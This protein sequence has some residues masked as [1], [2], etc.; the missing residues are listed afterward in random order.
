MFIK[1]YDKTAIVY[2]ER[3]I[4]YTN[5]IDMI[6][7]YTTLY[8]ATKRDRIAIF[9]ENCPEWA[10]AFF[11]SWAKGGTNV[12]IDM[13]STKEEVA[14]ILTDCTPSVIF[15]SDKTSAVMDEA[16]N[17]SGCSAAIINLDKTANPSLPSQLEDYTFADSDIPLILYT[18]GTTGTSKGVMLSWLNLRSNIYWNNSNKRINISDRMLAVLPAHHSWPL[19]ATILCPFDCGAT[20]VYLKTLNAEELVRTMKEQK[21]TMLTAVPR[22]FEMLHKGIMAKIKA[23]AAARILFRL[24]RALDIMPL[25]RTVFAKVHREFGG[26]IKVWIAGGAKLDNEIIK[27]YRALGILMLEGYGLTETSPM[28]T[29]HPF[30]NQR[31]G[32]VGRVFDETEIRFGEDDEIMLKGP[33][34]MTGY[35]NK[36]EAT[37]EVLVDG[38]LHTGDLG[39]IDNDRFLYITGRKKDIIVLPNGKNI[40]PDLIEEDILRN[41]PLI[42]ECAITEK[43]GQLFAIIKTDPEKI[44]EQRITNL[45]ETIKWGVI[46]L[47]NQNAKSY[48]RIHDF[49]ITVDDL[50]RTRMGKLRRYMLASFLTE[51]R[52]EKKA[53][54]IPTFEE[55]EDIAKQIAYLVDRDVHPDEHFEID[56]GMDSLSLVELQVFAEKTYGVTLEHGWTSHYPTVKTFAEHIRDTKTK[57][58]LQSFDWGKILSEESLHAPKPRDWVLRVMLRL[59]KL[60]FGRRVRVSAQGSENIPDGRC[61]IAPNHQSFI[62]SFVLMY[63]LPRRVRSTIFF[64]A[65]EKNFRSI[66]ARFFAKRSNTIIMDI[67]R[68]L[69]TSIRKIAAVLKAGYRV[70]IFPEGARSRSGKT[71]LFKKTFAIIASELGIPVVPVAIKGAYEALPINA[72]LPIKSIVSVTFCPPVLPSGKDALA[73]LEETRESILQN[74]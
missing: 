67:N 33:H 34:I 70:V 24:T 43:E 55:Y 65:K 32:S 53:V 40:R 38:W 26:C 41:Y 27:D 8:S 36:P 48:N 42:K 35:W 6:H 23:N 19:M 73:V 63:R 2:G 21:I 14:Y 60:F 25:S 20:V 16:V 46:D 61:I 44:R 49:I 10:F 74:L 29:Y 28:A 51:T 45:S 50:P 7:R 4:S 58:E 66:I 3:T 62:D 59:F 69:V 47:Y 72:K 30:D 39:R 5:F 13:F 15:V 22:L 56:L 12:L 11:S 71:G 64:L 17:L 37:A 31:I 54:E 52:K 18:S 57:H 1:D 68:D 9:S